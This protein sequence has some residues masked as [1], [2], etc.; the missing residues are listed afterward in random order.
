MAARRHLNRAPII[1]AIV[2]IR[3]KASAALTV[4][5]FARLE[6]PLRTDYPTV[7][8][9]RY[10]ESTIHLDAEKG[11]THSTESR[12]SGYR[13]ASADGLEI[14]QYRVDG[15]TFNRLAPYTSW[16]D[17]SP[18]AM[19]GWQ[20]YREVAAPE[21]VTRIALRYINRMELPDG[22]KDFEDV[23]TAPPPIPKTLPQSVS[24]FLTRVTVHAT[25]TGAAAHIT[26]TLVAD[27]A[28]TE[29][30]LIF[31]VDCFMQQDVEPESKLIEDNFA[32]L[33]ELKNDIFFESLTEDFVA[34]F[35]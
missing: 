34:R 25:D 19:K 5:E 3:V 13:F 35:E 9:I 2:D 33:R 24:R 22:M 4:E 11:A 17:I 28:G 6:E 23:M 12:V 16:Q 18:K 21:M 30:K 31:D 8:L 26:Q 15:F 20:I 32:L 27:P 29:P 1:E 10:H 14:V 7:N